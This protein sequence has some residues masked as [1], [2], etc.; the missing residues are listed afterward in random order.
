M[1]KKNEG[2]FKRHSST[3]KLNQL[4]INFSWTCITL[5]LITIFQLPVALKAT[6]ELSC[7]FQSLTNNELNN[8]WCSYK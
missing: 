8:S 6:I 5:T 7:I 4:G 2:P 1:Y 3:K